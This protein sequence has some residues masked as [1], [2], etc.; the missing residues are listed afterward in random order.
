MK[1]FP[2]YIAADIPAASVSQTTGPKDSACTSTPADTEG[3]DNVTL[4]N[5]IDTDGNLHIDGTEYYLHL[6]DKYITQNPGL[7]MPSEYN[8]IGDYITAQFEQ[9]K[10]FAGDD[11]E[12]NID[13]FT[14]NCVCSGQKSRE[15]SAGIN[16]FV[17]GQA[18]KF[19]FN[20]IFRQ[21]DSTKNSHRIL[22]GTQILL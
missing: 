2:K 18:L 6:V 11:C 22:I 7:Q 20:Y 15:Y 17:K 9:F 21:D 13:E 10:Q 8:N 19:M 14:P 12:M 4:F 5:N 3:T 1:K 16:Y